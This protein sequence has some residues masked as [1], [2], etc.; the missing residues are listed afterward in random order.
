MPW[1]RWTVRDVRRI[2]DERVR[3]FIPEVYRYSPLY[4]RLWSEA[5]VDVDRIRSVADLRA[6]PFSSKADICPT[7]DD[8]KK[9]MGVVLQPTP[10]ELRRNMGMLAKLKL[11]GGALAGRDP[12]QA[13]LDRYLPIHIISTTGRSANSVPFLYTYDD[14]ATLK[15]AG[16]R[17]FALIGLESTQDAILHA[18]PYAPHLAFW[19]VAFAGFEARLRILHT[20]GGKVMS[21]D[22]V[23]GLL[24]KTE[25][26]ALVGTPGYVYHLALTASTR[27]IRLPKLRMCILGAEKVNE[28]FKA[29]LKELLAGCGAADVRVHSTYGLTEAKHAWMECADAPDSRYHLYP[30]LELFEVVNP[31]TGEPV[32]DGERG[33]LVLTKLSGAGSV[34][35]RYRTGD[36]VEGGIVVEPCPH[37]GRVTALLDKRIGR[38]SEIKKVKGAL[39]DFNEIFGWFSARPEI[40]EW[41]L[42]LGNKNDDP[43]EVDELRLKVVLRDGV[44]HDVFEQ[45]INAAARDKFEV[46]FD[47]FYYYT[48][49]DLAELL[50]MDRL[51]K[52]ARIVDKRG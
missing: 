43:F 39:L 20:G 38:V 45:E 42:E 49:A 50:G 13:M 30:D 36:I 22:T 19:Q 18:F 32:A 12:K 17:M 35:V 48:H 28:P 46:R 33:E 7:P 26:T 9:Y 21:T 23:L 40:V 51:P 6:L 31:E 29:K 15:L 34:V 47:R 37:C 41:Q 52:E 8:P 5:G 1:K 14:M 11:A 2:Q 25:S 4:K 24:E 16:R 10:D 27:G 3:A 44:N